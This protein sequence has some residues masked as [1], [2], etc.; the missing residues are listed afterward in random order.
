LALVSDQIEDKLNSIFYNNAALALTS[1]RPESVSVAISFI[2]NQVQSEDQNTAKYLSQFGYT[3][4]KDREHQ[5]A[6]TDCLA[7]LSYRSQLPL[8]C[9]SW[10]NLTHTM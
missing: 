9:L 10:L 4:A 2:T 7:L 6:Q 3:F 8:D 1:K 5:M